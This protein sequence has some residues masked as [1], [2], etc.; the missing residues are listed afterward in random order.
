MQIIKPQ[1]F[2]TTRV[3]E[4]EHA[5]SVGMSFTPRFNAPE[6]QESPK[7]ISLGAHSTTKKNPACSLIKFNK[8]ENVSITKS[9]DKGSVIQGFNLEKDRDDTK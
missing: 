3:D 7:D 1:R 2:T 8:D 9:T 6:T 5:A 4:A